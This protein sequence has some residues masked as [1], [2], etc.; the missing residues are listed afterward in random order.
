M[1]ISAFSRR[2][3]HRHYPKPTPRPSFFKFNPKLDPFLSQFRGDST[4]GTV[5]EI[6]GNPPF[7]KVIPSTDITISLLLNPGTSPKPWLVRWSTG[8]DK[9]K[10]TFYRVY[11][12]S[13]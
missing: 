3:D 12:C 2:D 5:E 11:G 8:G 1:P 9:S 13:W 6:D 10:H 4:G 7:F